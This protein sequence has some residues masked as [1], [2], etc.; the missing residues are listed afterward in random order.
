MPASLTLQEISF[1]QAKKQTITP[2]SI[3]LSKGARVAIVGLNGAG[4]TTLLKI[5]VGELKP[6]QGIVKFSNGRQ[7]P[8]IIANSQ[9]GYQAA[10]M[11]AFSELTAH[12]YLQLCCSLKNHSIS[13]AEQ[14]IRNVNELWDLEKIL[15]IPVKKLSQGNLRKLSI[16]Q[17]FLGNPEYIILDEPTQAL[18][19]IEQERFIGNLL[20]LK[21]HHLCLFTS[22][23]VNEAV[24]AAENVIMMHQGSVVANLEFADKQ[25]FWVVTQG[26]LEEI[27]SVDELTFELSY[28]GR[29]KNLY[30]VSGSSLSRQKFQQVAH[31]QNLEV[32]VLGNHSEALMSIFNSLANNEL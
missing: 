27:D 6:T 12:E 9:L 3:S 1:R 22:H 11:A 4:K 30:K 15:N 25:S 26:A 17:A 24:R 20:G 10:D 29:F 8:Q 16:A 31:D 28:H 13:E 19:P 32:L 21:N 14:C 7:L 18:D 5:I 23:H 2:T